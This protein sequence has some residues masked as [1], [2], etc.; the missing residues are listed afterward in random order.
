MHIDRKISFEGG[1]GGNR[2]L[3][4]RQRLLHLLEQR[5]IFLERLN[6]QIASIRKHAL[7]ETRERSIGRADID[8]GTR[9]ESIVRACSSVWSTDSL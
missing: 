1:R 3:D 9:Y 6:E 8:D 7:T 4:G 5:S 2:E